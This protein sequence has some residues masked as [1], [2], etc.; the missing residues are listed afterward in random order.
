M[1]EQN[2]TVAETVELIDHRM[3]MTHSPTIGKLVEALCKAQLKF[4]PILKQTENAAFTRGSRVSYYADLAAY[5]DATQEAL[6]SEGLAVLQWP[7][8]SPEAKNMTLESMLAHSSGEWMRSTLTLPAL[9]RDGFTPQ[10]CGSS[11]TY[12]RRYSYAAIT[13]CAAEDDDGNAATGIGSKEAAKK[14]G[15][16][17]IAEANAP[18]VKEGAALFYVWNDEEQ[19]A[20]LTGDK[21]LMALN[22]ELLLSLGKWNAKEG[23]IIYNSD[24]FESL[25][26]ELEQRKVPL[27]ALQKAS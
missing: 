16:S 3:R 25:K 6:A 1:P 21:E 17:K 24:S 5:I 2:E 8:V 19:K 10:S 4:K 9:G 12:A 26:Y 7:D 22:K 23:A 20:Y 27:K 11:I 18:R 15:D 14:T 13:G